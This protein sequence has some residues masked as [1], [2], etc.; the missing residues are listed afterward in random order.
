MYFIKPCL[1]IFPGVG[2]DRNLP[3]MMSEHTHIIFSVSIEN[4]LDEVSTLAY[5]NKGENEYFTNHI[6]FPKF[7]VIL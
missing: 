1:K 7:Q 4:V 5:L 6:N 2:E 3:V